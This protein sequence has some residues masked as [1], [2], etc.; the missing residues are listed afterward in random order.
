MSSPTRH[1]VEHYLALEYSFNVVA[2]PMGG[3]VIEIPDLPG[4]MTQ[5]ESLDE[6]P[7]MIEDV[8]RG[9]IRTA[10]DRGLEIPLPSAPLDYSG[11]FNL[12]VP[13]SLHQQLDRGADR[14]GISLNQYVVSLLSERDGSARLATALDSFEL[15]FD[16]RLAAIERRLN[17]TETTVRYEMRSVPHL[18]S[19]STAVRRVAA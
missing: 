12:R 4:C 18:G 16:E 15:R 7:A 6:L 5:V 10:Y 9:W 1:P 17:A 2:D 13:R 3:Y 14:E 11:K 8:R 19:Y